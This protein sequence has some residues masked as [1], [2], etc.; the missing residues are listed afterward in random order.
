MLVLYKQCSLRLWYVF[1][2]LLSFFLLLRRPPTSTLF[3][4]TTLFRS[5]TFT[6][7]ILGLHS[8]EGGNNEALDGVMNMVLDIRK[9]AKENKDWPTADK[10]RDGLKEAGVEV[11]DGKE[12]STYKLN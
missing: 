2:L 3:P 12:G 11:M 10:I 9:S 5:H 6:F 4:Y 1:W 7:G 8:E